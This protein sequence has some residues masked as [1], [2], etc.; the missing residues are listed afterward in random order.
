MVPGI[1]LISEHLE[2]NFAKYKKIAILA[3]PNRDFVQ[4]SGIIGN[5]FLLFH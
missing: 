5:Y 1:I 2:K 3:Q 4:P